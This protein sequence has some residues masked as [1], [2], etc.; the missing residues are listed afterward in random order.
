MH[1]ILVYITFYFD[2]CPECNFATRE[3]ACKNFDQQKTA[4]KIRYIFLPLFSTLIYI[5]IY[6]YIYMVEFL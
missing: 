4:N 2:L 1:F 3:T 5:Y 6:I